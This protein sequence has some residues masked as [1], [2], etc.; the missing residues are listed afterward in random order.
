MRTSVFLSKFLLDEPS[1]EYSSSVFDLGIKEKLNIPNLTKLLIHFYFTSNLI[2][3]VWWTW[4]YRWFALQIF[5]AATVYG[6]YHGLV[7]LPV[8]LSL[9][10]P[11]PYPTAATSPTSRDRHK[12]LVDEHQ[13]EH[14]EELLTTKPECGNMTQ[15][16]AVEGRI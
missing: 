3:Q 2:S 5:F 1:L 9:M 7:V 14:Q 11:A 12:I 8:L 4:Y 6:L 15:L 10:G 13:P 16:D